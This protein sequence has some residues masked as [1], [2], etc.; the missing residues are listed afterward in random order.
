MFTNKTLTVKENCICTC[1]SVAQRLRSKLKL[2]CIR[3][4]AKGVIYESKHSIFCLCVQFHGKHESKDLNQTYIYRQIDNY[5]LHRNRPY[6]FERNRKFRSP[7]ITLRY[8]HT[9]VYSDIFFQF[10]HAVI[11]DY[12]PCMRGVKKK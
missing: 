11:D 4:R 10:P 6:W 5:R 9:T 1:L 2:K 3:S 7:E 12:V 8:N